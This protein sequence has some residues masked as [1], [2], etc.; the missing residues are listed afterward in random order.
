MKTET[1]GV[2]ER[3]QIGICFYGLTKTLK[4][5]Y[6][7][8]KLNVID[9]FKKDYN[10]KIYLHTY[11]LKEITNTRNGENKAPIS[12]SEWMMLNPDKYIIENQ[13]DFDK[14]QNWESIFLGKKDT[15]E[16]NYVSFKNIIRQSNSLEKVTNLWENDSI[17]FKALIYVRPDTEIPFSI[18]LDDI[19]N[20]KD[21]ELYLNTRI[22]PYPNDR[23][24]YGGPKAMSVYGHRLKSTINEMKKIFYGG[25]YYLDVV[26]KKN[27]DI[28]VKHT[29]VCTIRRRPPTNK[30]S[31]YD[32]ECLRVA[33]KKE[34]FE[35]QNDRRLQTSFAPELRSASKDTAS[36]YLK[37][38]NVVD[39]K[40]ILILIILIILIIV[41]LIFAKLAL[42]AK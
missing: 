2:N 22:S 31:E 10:I 4:H 21:N 16:N 42:R 8:I 15:F 12:P 24:A 41:F 36:P 34:N 17:K 6:E 32:A 27:K 29:G 25:E 5:N 3:S 39:F 38:S 37:K 28:V 11:N 9:H 23:F 26:L 18:N 13:D 30:I 19:A 33:L 7:S 35:S 40:I 1:I 14:L 20:I